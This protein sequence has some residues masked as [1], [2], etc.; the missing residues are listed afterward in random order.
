MMALRLLRSEAFDGGA[1]IVASH[2]AGLG[3]DVTLVTCLADDEKSRRVEARLAGRGV[4]LVALRQRRELVT[5]HRY[6]VDHT[7]MMK[8]DDGGASPLDS[9]QS[10]EMLDAVLAA[11]D[12]AA[13]VIFADFG[14][15]AITGPLLDRLVPA[16]RPRVPVITADVSGTH[17]SLLRFKGVDLLCPTERELRQ[18][19]NDFSSGLNAVMHRLF[20]TTGAKQALIT[21]GKQG[22]VAFDQCRKTA[23]GESWERKLRSAY[24]PSLAS[25][26]IDPLGCGDALLATAS[27]ALAAGE[28]LH[29]A[30]YLGSIAASIAAQR[31]GNHP[32]TADGVVARLNQ[33]LQ[34]VAYPA[35]L[36]S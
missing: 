35:R 26:A 18:T 5:K 11:A 12:G 19:L 3:A 13:G 25:N 31:L 34:T 28:P 20:S 30:A 16:L 6:L 24:L 8:V 15:G 14:Y 2:L 22:F 17:A 23:P 32:I 1:A 33:S 29:A 7:K 21:M 10:A 9:T 27:L 4:N 36:A